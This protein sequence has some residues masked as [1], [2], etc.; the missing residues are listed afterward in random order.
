MLRVK[1]DEVTERWGVKVTSVE[2]REIVPPKEI[3]DAMN[4]QMSAE[5][6]RR[7]MVTESKGKRQSSILVAEGEKQSTILRAEGDRRSAI[8]K[9]EGFSLALEKIFKSAKGIGPKT[10]ALQYLDALK[11][12]GASPSTKYFFPMELMEFLKPLKSYVEQAGQE[13]ADTKDTMG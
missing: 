10:M 6:N 1:L 7:A 13:R 4:R 9:A 2:I 5:R 3:Q 11:T 12:I 8:L